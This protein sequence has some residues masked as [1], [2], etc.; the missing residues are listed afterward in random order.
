MKIYLVEDI[1]GPDADA[2][3]IKAF[4][5]EADAKAEVKKMF[6]DF[7]DA[8]YDVKD[9][10]D[11]ENAETIDG[12][13]Y[14]TMYD[15]PGKVTIHAKHVNAEKVSDIWVVQNRCYPS[16][17][18]KGM[19]SIVVS[20]EEGVRLLSGLAKKYEEPVAAYYKRGTEIMPDFNGEDRMDIDHLDYMEKNGDSSFTH[21]S[22]CLR[23]VHVS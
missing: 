16:Q 3:P 23:K 14:N 15:G 2:M 4:L 20:Q 12:F 1:C 19:P 5:T 21:C 6:K 10:D 22:F 7:V 9:K 8:H 13:S 18:I 17:Y 11:L